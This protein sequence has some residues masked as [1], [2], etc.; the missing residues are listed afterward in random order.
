M[1][2]LTDVAKRSKETYQLK[3]LKVEIAA[4]KTDSTLDSFVDVTRFVRGG[5]IETLRKSIDTNDFTI[6]L[7]DQNNINIVFDN[8]NGFF[9]NNSGF[10]TNRIEH[11]SKV[12]IH[13]GYYNNE[14]IPITSSSGISSEIS[15]EGI[16][17]SEGTS[18]ESRRETTK[19]KVLSYISIIKGLKTKSG[20]VTNGMDFQ[21][22]FFNLLNVFEITQ[23]LTVDV[24]NINPDV[25]LTIDDGTFFEGLQLNDAIDKLLLASNSVLNIVNNEIII[26]SRKEILNIKYEFYGKGSVFPAN[27][28]N[29]FNENPGQRRV[30]TRIQFEGFSDIFEAQ[31]AVIDRF[32]ARL[33]KIDLG[34]ITDINTLETIANTILN[35]FQFP[36]RELEVETSYIGNQLELLDLVTID[37]PG[38]VFDPNASRYNSSKYGTAIYSTP[39]AGLKITQRTGFKVLAIDHNFS[40]FTTKLKLRE[41]GTKLYDS[42]LNVGT[43]GQFVYGVAVYGSSDYT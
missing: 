42:D 21:T 34:F 19:Y 16:I 35:E 36:K 14:D 15:F 17:N 1:A 23:Y 7:F 38:Y 6:G 32:G 9:N 22:A 37:N 3:F 30:I 10:F 40:R 28:T 12:R 39:Q 31:T 4:R 18:R 20:A 41:I 26:K 13:A 5:G 24:G 8:S 2:I 25:N 43:G 11:R 29:I 33:K 27:V